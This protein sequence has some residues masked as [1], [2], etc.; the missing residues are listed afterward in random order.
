MKVSTD[1][2]ESVAPR[3]VSTNDY[4]VTLNYSRDKDDVRDQEELESDIADRS[5]RQDSGES[6][7]HK[8]HG[9]PSNPT[10]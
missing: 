5:H 6:E 3:D 9:T 4:H 2:E 7:C 10:M 1:D 8:S